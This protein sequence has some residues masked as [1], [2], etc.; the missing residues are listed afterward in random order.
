[1]E[2]E[3]DEGGGALYEC[4]SDREGEEGSG[5]SGE[6]GEGI[7]RANEIVRDGGD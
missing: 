1:M 3:C 7:S 2:G 5:D 6:H 4:E